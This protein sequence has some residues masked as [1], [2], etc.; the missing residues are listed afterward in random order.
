[1]T[2]RHPWAEPGIEPP[3]AE[4]LVDPITVAVMTVDG[5]RI[6]EVVAI[7]E[8]VRA[9]LSTRQPLNL[10]LLRAPG[11]RDLTPGAMGL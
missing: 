2:R 4:L 6:R 10:R 7:I 11:T 5:V 8:S 3:L 9:G 1:M